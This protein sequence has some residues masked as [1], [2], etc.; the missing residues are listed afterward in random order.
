MEQLYW[1]D[2]LAVAV[3]LERVKN[4]ELISKLGIY[5]FKSPNQIHE[6]PLKILAVKDFPFLNEL[7]KLIKQASESG[8][9]VKWLKGCRFGPTSDKEPLFQYME[10]NLELFIAIII[11]NIIAQLFIYSILTLEKKAYNKIHQQN[12]HSFWK[13]TELMINPD[14]YV[15]MEI[16]ID[17]LDL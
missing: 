14:R 13:W 12:V 15:S 16:S 6:Y 2:N 17:S 11:I 8:L 1:D 9:I 7:N 3:S 4:E 10:V 5:C